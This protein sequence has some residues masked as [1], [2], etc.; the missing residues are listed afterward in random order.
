MHHYPP[1]VL[2]HGAWHGAWCWNRTQFH[3]A[4]L[5]RMAVAVDLP[6]H[7]LRAL[8]PRAQRARPFSSEAMAAEPSRAGAI[9]LGEAA[10]FL[11]G[12]IEALSIATGSRVALVAHSLGGAIANAA[13]EIAAEHLSH[14]VHLCAI[15]PVDGHAALEYRMAPE[16]E[17]SRTASLQTGHPP[18]IGAARIDAADEARLQ[19]IRQ[20]FFHDIDED[21]ARAATHFMT[22]DVPLGFLRDPVITTGRFAAI[23]RAYI[24]CTQDNALREPA[25]RRCIADMDRA[26]PDAPTRVSTLAS[27]H[28]PFFSCPDRLAALI[29]MHSK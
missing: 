18:E 15:T 17:G 9:S 13:A 1:L 10:S 4:L 8:F 23:P 24:V 11:A 27:S 20:I 5:N 29:D 7:G 6:N 2:V 19:D 21:A 22:P 12:Q 16:N 28:S 25:Q 3:L 26:Y 14:L